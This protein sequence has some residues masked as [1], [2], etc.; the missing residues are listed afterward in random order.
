MQTVEPFRPYRQLLIGLDA[1]EW[2]L[3]L[4]WTKQGKLPIFRRLMEQ[5]IHAELSTTSE[6]L[7]DTVWASL[8]TG[9][10]PA[11]FQKY[12]YVQ[13][14]PKR[15][16]LRH[17]TD[18]AILKTPFWEFLSQSG[19]RVGIVDVPKFQLSRS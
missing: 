17:V 9:T 15:L 6:Q 11:K 19:R 14:D 2:D 3:V 8:Y 5:G 18:D 10:N 12:F 16:R 1:M 4:R 13:Y 7:P